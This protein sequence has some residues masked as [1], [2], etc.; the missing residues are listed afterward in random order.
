MKG[1]KVKMQKSPNVT[2]F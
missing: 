1:N 2:S